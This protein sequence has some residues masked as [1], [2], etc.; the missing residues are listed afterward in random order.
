L[1]VGFLVFTFL[2]PGW[3]PPK[4]ELFLY[5]PRK[6]SVFLQFCLFYLRLSLTLFS[7]FVGS[8]PHLPLVKLPPNDVS[9]AFPQQPFILSRVMFPSFRFS[10]AS[11]HIP[12]VFPRHFSTGRKA[13]PLA[14][15]VHISFVAPFFSYRGFPIV[16]GPSY[17]IFLAPW[18]SVLFFFCCFFFFTFPSPK[19]V[20]RQDSQ[21]PRLSE[22][23]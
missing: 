20:F 12:R 15:F 11:I 3:F 4:L 19:T 18:R 13:T 6:C 21:L 17:G 8:L 16:S 14:P 1:T 2:N 7:P 10:Y 22:K 23:C 5:F 9:F